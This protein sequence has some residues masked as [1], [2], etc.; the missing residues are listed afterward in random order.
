MPYHGEVLVFPAL[1]RERVLEQHRELRVLLQALTADADGDG[2]LDWEPNLV[3]IGA[4]ARELCD[5]FRAHLAFEEEELTP[6]LAVLD[7]WGPERVRDLQQDHVRQ[8]RALDAFLE[9]I[10]DG[11]D[12][13]WVMGAVR[14]LAEDLLRDMAEEE[15]GCLR[16]GLLARQVLTI[17][18]R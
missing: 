14:D 7:G 8:R 1:V 17:E 15:A 4:G 16:T 3:Q 5:L 9:R 11:V 2:D 6:V 13:R 18:R 12:A 10:A